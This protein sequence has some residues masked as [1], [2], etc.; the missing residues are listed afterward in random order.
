MRQR[1]GLSQ[2]LL[3]HRRVALLDEPTSG[4]DPVS[5][6]D[7][8]SVVD[9]MAGNGAALLIAS[10][11]LTELEARTDRIVILRKGKIVAD[12]SL[13]NLVR[14]A[15]LPIRIRLVA[16]EGAADRVRAELGGTR[17][18]GTA[19]ELNCTADD[20]MAQI[21][22]ISALGDA[23]R[24]VEMIPPSLEDLYRHYSGEE[25]R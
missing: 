17:L 23:V 8:Y 16:Q 19:V 5:R 21:T 25:M 11:A 22:R 1:L 3:G 18:N 13:T 12:D 14:A 2:T 10:H 24:D 9:E 20:K 7:L 15:V 4:L 6:H